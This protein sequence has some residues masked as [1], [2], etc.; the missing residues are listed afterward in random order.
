[1]NGTNSGSIGSLGP[2]SP[3]SYLHE[4]KVDPEQQEVVNTRSSHVHF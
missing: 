1:M 3:G 2:A 4:A